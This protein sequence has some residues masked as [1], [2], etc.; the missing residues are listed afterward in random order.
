RVHRRVAPISVSSRAGAARGQTPRAADRRRRR[1]DPPGLARPRASRA[2]RGTRAMRARV[3]ITG[4][5]LVTAIGTS[6]DET[7]ANLVRGGGG[8]R[9]LWLFD[10][11]GYRSQIAGEVD[12]DSLLPRFT[13]L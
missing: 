3:A 10:T 7:W 11:E 8:I 9:P 1:R 2:A 4:I 13:P 12:H 6:R 5:G